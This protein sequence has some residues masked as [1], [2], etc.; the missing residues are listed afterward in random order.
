MTFK[1]KKKISPLIKEYRFNFGVHR[2]K[3]L[4]DVPEDYLRQLM[5]FDW[6][7][8]FDRTVYKTYLD[9]KKEYKIPNYINKA[10][11]T[12]YLMAKWDKDRKD[13]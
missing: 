5:A 12:M 1:L 2:G 6:I 8:N 4:N 3:S 13:E 10:Q 11:Y 9:A 7:S